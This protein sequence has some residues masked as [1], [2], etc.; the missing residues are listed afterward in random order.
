MNTIKKFNKTRVLIVGSGIIGKFN[1]LE[2]SKLGF[3]ITIVDEL[4][5]QNSSNAALGLLMGNIYQKRKGR[6]WALRRK[7]L[8]LWPLWLDFLNKYNSELKIEKPLLQLTTDLRKFQRLVEFASNYPK[9]DFEI[10]AKDSHLLNQVNKVF[11]KNNLQGL[12]SYKDGR[13]NPSILLKTL[14]TALSA[15]DIKQLNNQIT[16]IKKDK[17]R[18]ISELKTG[19]SITNEII[20][21]CNSLDSL[22]L[23]DREKYRFKLKPVIGQGIEIICEDKNINF[24]SLPQHFSINGKNLIPL[25]QNKIIIGSTD[26]YS[27]KPKEEYINELINFVKYKPYWL[28]KK[29]I[30]KNWFGIRSR[31]EGQP[32]PIL[33]SLEEG[34]IICSGFYKNGF[35]LAPACSNWISK[36]IWKHL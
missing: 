8:E 5:K 15:K 33:Q 12:I 35:L 1:A 14:N 3:Q 36:E 18:W 28:D 17:N 26:E 23:I 13:I 10:L 25:S 7:S 29:N 11:K 2:L 32:S 19:E 31:P 34:L 16:L 4:E 30:S 27:F 22:M 20:I 9:D 24:L 6:S 21:L